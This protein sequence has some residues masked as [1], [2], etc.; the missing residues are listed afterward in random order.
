MRRGL[1]W[2]A[3]AL[4]L[5]ALVRLRRR[6]E[7]PAAPAVDPAAELRAKLAQ[8]RDAGDDRDAFEAAEGVPVDEAEAPR[9]IEERRAAIHAKAQ[10]ALGEMREGPGD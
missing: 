6:R 1:T 4:G 9:S 8:A 7:A 3:G 5:A 10:E 2:L